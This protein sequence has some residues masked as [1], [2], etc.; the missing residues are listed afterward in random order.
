MGAEALHATHPTLVSVAALSILWAYR[1]WA[2]RPAVR[3]SVGA[4]EGRS[5]RGDAC[6]GPGVRLQGG[7][8]LPAWSSLVLPV[9][10]L[11]D[12]RHVAACA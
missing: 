10:L 5:A 1:P 9:A 8:G 7:N 6:M 11:F 4:G 12:R 2:V 3:L